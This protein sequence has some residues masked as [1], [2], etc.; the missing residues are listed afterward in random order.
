[1][2]RLCG[3]SPLLWQVGAT[4]EAAFLLGIVQV[5]IARAACG[6]AQPSAVNA[7]TATTAGGGGDGDMTPSICPLTDGMTRGGVWWLSEE[8]LRAIDAYLAQTHPALS[9]RRIVTC[10]KRTLSGALVPVR[11]WVHVHDAAV[12]DALRTA[13]DVL[14]A[15][16]SEERSEPRPFP[17]LPFSSPPPPSPPPPL[18]SR[19]FYA[20]P[21]LPC[22]MAG[23][24]SSC[25]VALRVRS[26]SSAMSAPRPSRL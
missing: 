16:P 7:A 6:A 11:A 9:R 25:G 21:L 23:V 14:F 2:D 26:H 12:Q 18:A 17:V 1:M 19:C 22:A 3:G 15:L 20:A 10:H 8:E 4:P 13:A 5:W 24:K